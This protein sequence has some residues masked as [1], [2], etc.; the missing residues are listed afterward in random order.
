MSSLCWQGLC[1]IGVDI[2]GIRFLNLQC[3]AVLQRWFILWG[4]SHILICCVLREAVC[5]WLLISLQ[6]LCLAHRNK[7]CTSI[8]SSSNWGRQ[9]VAGCK[10]CVIWG[11]EGWQVAIQRQAK[12]WA[13]AKF[14]IHCWIMERNSLAMGLM[15][16]C[17]CQTHPLCYW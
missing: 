17:N 13:F 10:A 7:L 11:V 12:V 5:T 8:V 3:W 1:C 2:Q 14:C 4:P 9:P 6:Q 15:T 16:Q